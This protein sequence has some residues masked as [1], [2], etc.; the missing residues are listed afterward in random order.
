M[1]GKTKRQNEITR[2][3][4]SDTG[5]ILHLSEIGAIHLL[6]F[7]GDVFIPPLVEVEFEANTQGWSPPQWIQT[8]ELDET[9][10]AKAEKWVK[11]KD[12]DAG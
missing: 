6:S 2:I 4:V 11:A 8:I 5:P 12:I 3:V 7:T 1:G 9:A 10:K